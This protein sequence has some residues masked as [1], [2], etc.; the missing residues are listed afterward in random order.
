MVDLAPYPPNDLSAIRPSAVLFACDL[1]G[2][3]SPMAESLLKF[4][5]GREIFVDSAG[6]KKGEINPFAIAVMDEIGIDLSR[7]RS[8]SFD[9]LE[10]TSFDLIISLTPQAHQKAAL[11]TRTMACDI[12]Y[13]PTPDPMLVQG[14]RDQMLDAYREVRDSL[15]RRLIAQFGKPS[16]VS[17]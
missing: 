9:E 3:R 11:L 10:D 12:L 8:K 1:N 4:L 2:T 14:S 13:W 16:G 7:H 15:Q 5:H 17:V 6:V